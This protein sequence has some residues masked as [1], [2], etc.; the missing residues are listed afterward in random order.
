MGEFVD[1]G[2]FRIDKDI[3]LPLA[4]FAFMMDDTV[5]GHFIGSLT[6]PSKSE[7]IEPVSMSAFRTGTKFII[8]GFV[9]FGSRLHRNN[10]G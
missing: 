6:E 10:S 8:T 5:P 2:D 7:W 9:N 4:F 1:P 3:S